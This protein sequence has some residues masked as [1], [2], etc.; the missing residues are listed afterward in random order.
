MKRRKFI[1][2]STVFVGLSI[3]GAN[4]LLESCRKQGITPSND[5]IPFEIDLS[6][7]PY[8]SL[9]IAGNY[10]Y[11]NGII[12]AN[13]GHG[14]VALSK[15]CTHQG[16]P[17]SYD[18]A[19]KRFPCPCHNARFGEDGSVLGGPTSTPLKS[20]HITQNGDILTIKG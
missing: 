8:K 10:I 9:N 5:A 7:S 20:Y 19:K 3:V 13:T 2:K 4:V 16:C 12:I 17:V 6:I 11:K 15:A 18:K 1:H 14:F